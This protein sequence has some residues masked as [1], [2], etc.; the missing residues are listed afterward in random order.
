AAAKDVYLHDVFDRDGR[1][2]ARVPLKR[3]PTLFRNGKLYSLEESEEG[4]PVIKRYRVIGASGT[5][6]SG[7]K[8]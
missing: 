2:I 8:G 5:S 7:N 6:P 4:Y 1:Y 3:I